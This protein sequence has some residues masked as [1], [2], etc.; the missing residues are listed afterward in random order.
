MGDEMFNQWEPIDQN[1]NLPPNYS[2]KLGLIGSIITVV[3]DVIGTLSIALEKDGIEE[4]EEIST[5]EIGNFKQVGSEKTISKSLPDIGF[6]LSLLSA[7]LVTFGD[8]VSTASIAI[9]IDESII[10]EQQDAQEKMEQEKQIRE[11]QNQINNLQKEMKSMLIIT[12]AMRREIISLQR[13]N[14]SKDFRR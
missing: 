11:M 13:A 1:N 10:Q 9:G 3:G 8:T 4:V 14:Y 2:T 5:K 6:V 7:I 12:D